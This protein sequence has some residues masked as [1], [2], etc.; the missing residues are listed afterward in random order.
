MRKILLLL[1]SLS[2]A[3]ILLSKDFEGIE[4]SD[5]GEL[6]LEDA[7]I[8]NDKLRLYKIGEDRSEI[9]KTIQFAGREAN[10]DKEF[11]AK[12]V[13]MIK[14][15]NVSEDA[16]IVLMDVL[17]LS[18]AE[19]QIGFIASYLLNE[20]SRLSFSASSAL[21][22]IGGNNALAALLSALSKAN[23][24][25]MRYILAALQSFHETSAIAPLVKVLETSEDSVS[26]GLALQALAVIPSE[27]ALEAIIVY[28]DRLSTA[29][30]K[31]DYV[32]ALMLSLIN[33]RGSVPSALRKEAIARI[34]QIGEGSYIK[35]F[36]FSEGLYDLP[37]GE[38]IK[39]LGSQDEVLRNASLDVLIRGGRSIPSA[40]L[41]ALLPSLDES[42]TIRLLPLLRGNVGNEALP[43]LGKYLESNNPL[44]GEEA[45]MVLGSINTE[46]SLSIL[47]SQTE[48]FPASVAERALE[49]I[50]GSLMPQLRKYVED[51]NPLLAAL[52]IR[53][54]VRL[55][56]T[57]VVP[58]LIAKLGSVDRD[59]SVTLLEAI[60]SLG[61][62]ASIMPLLESGDKVGVERCRN[63]I[64]DI[65]AR[66]PNEVTGVL[67][68]GW[69]T[70][71]VPL[72]V[73]VIEIY[74]VRQT[75]KELKKLLALLGDT[76]ASVRTATIRVLG[77]WKTSE[78]LNP[79]L[80]FA[81]KQQALREQVLSL[82]AIGSLLE[83]AQDI[84]PE[85]RKAAAEK[86]QSIATRE[87]EKQ[88][89]RS[90]L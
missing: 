80:D 29:S 51:P 68:S 66:Y 49:N 75:E 84:S 54:L 8:P 35:Q 85:V 88:I 74:G 56:D 76:D 1:F 83:R 71:T 82:R 69:S 28:G 21:V 42:V 20:N 43:L 24:E 70:L 2:V 79:L 3:S 78:P 13:T 18:G 73:Q 63:A 58:G 12:V 62:A 67:D 14:D 45:L 90:F 44:L 87:E 41:L 19:D 59:F 46:D 6:H 81:T 7:D 40:E 48:K 10:A 33:T 65:Y 38:L 47:F 72:K 60:G 26:Q 31:N 15:P 52:A 11:I 86:A 4:L 30:I 36:A 57:S 23:G 32:S 22:R 5:T 50:T 61:D 9:L 25:Q 53:Q 16:R 34:Q 17:G 39:N 27:K 89:F 64:L 37:T 77:S 55:E